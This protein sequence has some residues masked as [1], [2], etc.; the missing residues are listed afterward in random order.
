MKV[1][2]YQVD[3]FT[4]QLFGGNPAAVCFLPKWPDDQLLLNIAN[5]NDRKAPGEA[6]SAKSFFPHAKSQ[7]SFP[8]IPL[9]CHEQAE[10][11]Q[12][13]RRDDPA[14]IHLPGSFL[15]GNKGL[16]RQKFCMHLSC[17]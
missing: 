6:R 1:K 9:L 8:V 11:V 2:I 14:N 7:N 10:V 16:S 17:W 4:D 13:V 15:P 3:A 5:E 12:I